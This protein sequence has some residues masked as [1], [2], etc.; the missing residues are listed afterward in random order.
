MIFYS[1]DAKLNFQ[2]HHFS[3]MILHK[4][5]DISINITKKRNM[6]NYIYVVVIIHLFTF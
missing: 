2:H 3:H 5:F 4:S 6:L 1:C